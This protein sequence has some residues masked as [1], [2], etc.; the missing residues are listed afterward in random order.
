MT[1]QTQVDEARQKLE[2]ARQEAADK[3]KFSEEA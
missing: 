3:Q 2:Q 1:T